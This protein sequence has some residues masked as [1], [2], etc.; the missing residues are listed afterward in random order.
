M[1]F[2]ALPHIDALVID[3]S[4]FVQ[5]HPALVHEVGAHTL[6]HVLYSFIK[7][8]C[9]RKGLSRRQIRK[10]VHRRNR[11]FVDNIIMHHKRLHDRNRQVIIS[12]ARKRAINKKQ[13][14]NNFANT[15]ENV[16]LTSKLKNR[17]HFYDT[18]NYQESE[19]EKKKR[20]EKSEQ[21]KLRLQAKQ[22]RAKSRWI[23]TFGT[24]FKNDD[25][26]D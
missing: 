12:D 2:V 18:Q 16:S 10:I 21:I 22:H 4:S 3:A 13:M 11:W 9:N 20:Q 23:A 25:K 14:S 5:M 7:R 19:E 17:S 1:N 24:N 6:A 8:S 15:S 26:D